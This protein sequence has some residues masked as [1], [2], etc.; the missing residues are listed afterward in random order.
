[1]RKG[2]I[3]VPFFLHSTPYANRFTGKAGYD[4]LKKE[5]HSFLSKS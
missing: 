1:M 5:R 3:T 2:E 4:A